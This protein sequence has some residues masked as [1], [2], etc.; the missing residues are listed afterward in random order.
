MAE[1]LIMSARRDAQPA[2]SGHHLDSANTHGPT[3]KFTGFDS[4]GKDCAP[5]RHSSS[6]V[7]EPYEI[8]V[9]SRYAN[10]K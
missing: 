1:D 10:G 9:T 5:D 7:F 2:D 3:R 4:E 6:F 8:Y